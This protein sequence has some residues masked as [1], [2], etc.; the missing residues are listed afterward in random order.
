MD[1]IWT[2]LDEY[3]VKKTKPTCDIPHL[4]VLDKSSYN[5]R[6]RQLFWSNNGKLPPKSRQFSKLWRFREEPRFNDISIVLLLRPTRRVEQWVD[7]RDFSYN[8]NDFP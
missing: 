3:T 5:P 8:A 4:V 7:T 1:V 2:L 6:C